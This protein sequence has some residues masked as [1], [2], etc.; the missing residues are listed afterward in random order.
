MGEVRL[1]DRKIDWSTAK[2]SA[3]A[4]S[5]GRRSQCRTFGIAERRPRQQSG[6]DRSVIRWMSVK[7][8]AYGS[9]LA[10]LMGLVMLPGV[11]IFCGHAV[12]IECL[13]GS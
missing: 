1:D 13:R 12:L 11:S 2:C 10:T 6:H 3:V 9:V 7:N 5:D 8:I 4:G